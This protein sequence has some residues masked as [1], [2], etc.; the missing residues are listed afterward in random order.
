VTLSGCIDSNAGTFS[1][2]N[3]ITISPETV[4]VQHSW[5]AVFGTAL[6]LALAVLVSLAG[7]PGHVDGTVAALLC[8]F[9]AGMAYVIAGVREYLPLTAST[10]P[11][12]RFAGVGDLLLA[13]GMLLN[14][15]PMVR[16][17][18][19]TLFV[20]L[21]NAAGSLVIAAIGVDCF[22]GGVYLD[23]AAVE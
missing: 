10:A 20:G 1:T 21:L 4:P 7:V 16:A 14:A 19:F 3:N 12:Y 9:L 11:W 22:R 6:V 17:G 13:L 5:L 18:D 8:L 2:V 23:T 15:V